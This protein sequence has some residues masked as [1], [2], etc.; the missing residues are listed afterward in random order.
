[1]LARSALV[2]V[3]VFYLLPQHVVEQKSTAAMQHE[4]QTLLKFCAANGDDSRFHT[5]SPRVPLS[6]HPLHIFLETAVA[7]QS[8]VLCGTI[9]EKKKRGGV[10]EQET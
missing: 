7:L 4:L 5:F 6:E 3:D 1:M 10:W 9:V 8:L 2:L